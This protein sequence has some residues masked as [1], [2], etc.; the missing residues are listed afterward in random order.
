[1]TSFRVPRWARRVSVPQ[2]RSRHIKVSCA[3]DLICHLFVDSCGIGKPRATMAPLSTRS[4]S[5]D[6]E[7]ESD[8][9]IP[10]GRPIRRGTQ[11]RV[12]E[13]ERLQRWMNESDIAGRHDFQR[14]FLVRFHPPPDRPSSGT[15]SGPRRGASTITTAVL[16]AVSRSPSTTAMV[17][18]GTSASTA[19]LSSTVS[20]GQA[21]AGANSAP[22]HPPQ[23]TPRSHTQGS[24]QGQRI[25]AHNPHA[26]LPVRTAPA[27]ESPRR[28]AYP[29]PYGFLLCRMV[30]PDVNQWDAHVRGHFHE[31]LPLAVE[32]PFECT[33]TMTGRTGLAAW[34]ARNQH[35]RQAH[36]NTNPGTVQTNRPPS[37][38]LLRHLVENRLLPE[39]VR[40]ELTR[41]GRLRTR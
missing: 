23:P 3:P 6:D 10:N 26:V 35:I 40:A 7:S 22:S 37:S 21:S 31:R 13:H 27:V 1:M 9:H 34:T 41:Q 2:T 15:F 16:P 11:S 36:H 4:S 38:A 39:P 32:C 24:I 17:A 19:A 33:W 14:D 18:T 12:A 5:S 25:L 29:C 8:S 30:L 28:P 20:S